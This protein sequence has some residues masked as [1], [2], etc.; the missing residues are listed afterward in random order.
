[1]SALPQWLRIK[2]QSDFIEFYRKES[3]VYKTPYF[4]FLKQQNQALRLGV[5]VRKKTFKSAVSRNYLKRV[6]KTL[7]YRDRHLLSE[8]D[9]VVVARKP[10]ELEFHLIEKEWNQFVKNL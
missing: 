4:V 2:K 10:I 9:L 3:K 8:M 6:V 7:F 1:M 5:V